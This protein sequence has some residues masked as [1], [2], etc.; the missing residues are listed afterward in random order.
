M[1]VLLVVL[2]SVPII[3]CVVGVNASA[4]VGHA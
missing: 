3:S 4:F 2:G 1:L